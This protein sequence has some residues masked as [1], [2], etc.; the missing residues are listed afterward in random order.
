MEKIALQAPKNEIRGS[1]NSEAGST[2]DSMTTSIIQTRGEKVS[3]AA[4]KKANQ[5][6]HN[7]ITSTWITGIL[8]YNVTHA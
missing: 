6:W 5:S 1:L 3:L 4:S 2:S 8:D 7:A